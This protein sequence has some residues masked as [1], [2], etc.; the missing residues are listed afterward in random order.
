VRAEY[1]HTLQST[2][3]PISSPLASSMQASSAAN[4][5]ESIR[6]TKNVESVILE[7]YTGTVVS[8]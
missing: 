3:T 5:G 1:Y 7:L 4:A 8:S 2:Q 6:N